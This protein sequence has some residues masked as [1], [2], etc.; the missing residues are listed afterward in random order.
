[1]QQAAVDKPRLAMLADRIARPF[2]WVVLLTALAAAVF[3][4]D[5]DPARGLMAA[6]A[7]LVVTCPCALSLATPSAMLTSAGWLARRGVLMRRLQA[8]EAL[9]GID[10]VL[11]DKTGTLTE[12]RLGLR[13]IEL[14]TERRDW[15]QAQALQVA[16]ALARHSLHPVSRALVEHAG[17]RCPGVAWADWP[18]TQWHEESGRGLRAVPEGPSWPAAVHGPLRLG[19]AEFCGVPALIEAQGVQ[20]C[21]ADDQGLIARFVFEETVR[22]GAAEV[23]SAL[24]GAGLQVQLL[25][26]DRDASV[27]HL[28]ARVGLL[29]QQVRSQCTPQDKLSHLKALQAQGHRVLMVGDGLNDGPVLAQADVSMAVGPSVPLAQ[30]Q[31]DIVVPSAELGVILLLRRQAQQTLRI[32]RQNLI[33]SATYNAVC[34]PLALAGWL[35]A[36][37]AGLGM[38]LSSLLVVL[39]ASRLSMGQ[40]APTLTQ[41]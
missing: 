2:L 31:A 9:Q 1:M 12:A 40:T 32:V 16:A 39:N 27:Q 7:V 10:T 22:S 14:S 30:A 20:V 25:S 24:Q 35:P 28:A 21:L 4:W 18:L 15:T 36:W 5:Q 38:A 34:V 41:G 26:G 8:L 3:W 33:W 29:P 19:Q 17:R 6:V 23:V 37:A 11:F 13:Q